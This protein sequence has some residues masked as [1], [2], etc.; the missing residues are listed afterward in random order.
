MKKLIL[1]SLL[2]FSIVLSLH[3]QED[4]V[5][6]N[7]ENY[8]SVINPSYVGMSSKNNITLFSSINSFDFGYYS[9]FYSLSFDIPLNSISSG[10]GGNFNM[11]NQNIQDLYNL[12]LAYSYIFEFDDSR[13]GIGI[14]PGFS[15]SKPND[16]MIYLGPM[17]FPREQITIWSTRIGVYFEKNKFFAGLSSQQRLFVAPERALQRYGIPNQLYYLNSGYSFN[18]KDSDFTLTP[19]TLLISDY[20][21]L[22]VR[23]SGALDYKNIVKLGLN[24]DTGNTYSSFIE[25]TVFEVLTIGYSY[26]FFLDNTRN[27]TIGN[28]EFLLKYSFN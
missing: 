9:N 24:A 14:S 4:R 22:N 10:F 17:S 11:T 21:T 23:I 19:S 13:L 16:D 8:R 6:N 25:F 20:S 5:P 7:Y 12:N 2:V 27:T 18:F 28:H 26:G 3:S 1:L 15:M